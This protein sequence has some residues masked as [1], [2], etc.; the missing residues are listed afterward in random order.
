MTIG[1]IIVTLFTYELASANSYISNNIEIEDILGT[2][3]DDSLKND[4]TI[5]TIE[6]FNCRLKS[7]ELTV[8]N[9]HAKLET[10]LEGKSI[11]FC[12]QLHKNQLGYNSENA[13]FGISSEISG[14][15][16]LRK[17]LIEK[18]SSDIS[19]LQPNK[20]MLRHTVASVALY[21]MD[22]NKI[23]YFQFVCDGIDLPLD[24]KVDSNMAIYELA[25]Y[26]ARA[27]DEVEDEYTAMENSLVNEN[28]VEFGDDEVLQETDNN[29]IYALTPNTEGYVPEVSEDSRIIDDIIAQCQYGPID[30]NQRS[31]VANIPDS[32]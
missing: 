2:C 8:D 21:S 29:L 7:L 23:Y 22:T 27:Y 5:E 32:V 25:N 26:G 1:S 13:V 12:P 24:M 30:L 28:S 16:K 14:N 11:V 6:D 20:S 9:N 10:E 4:V 31:L 17:F 19:L 18:N 3:C 15:F